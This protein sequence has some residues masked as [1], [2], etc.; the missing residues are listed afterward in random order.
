MN[1]GHIALL[2][3]LTVALTGHAVAQTRDLPKPPT[4]AEF[5]KT[6]PDRGEFTT[7]STVKGREAVQQ[8]RSSMGLDAVD[9]ARFNMADPLLTDSTSL[10]ATIRHTESTSRSNALAVPAPDWATAQVAVG[11]TIT[12][13]WSEGGW[14]YTS[15][16]TWNGSEWE[17]TAF[18]A[19]KEKETS[20]KD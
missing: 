18:S 4:A 6:I 5:Q 16:V 7:S 11:D 12:Q 1:F 17:L 13:T 3:S 15:T 9:L 20:P 10:Q 14:T 8:L 2:T 19:E